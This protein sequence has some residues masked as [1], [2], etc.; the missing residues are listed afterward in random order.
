MCQSPSEDSLDS[1]ILPFMH[2]YSARAM[3][4]FSS[5]GLHPGQIPV[6]FAIK[7]KEGPTL[8]ELADCLHIKPP[9]VT[10]TVQRLEKAGILEKK[11]DEKDQ[12]IYHLYLTDKGEELLLRAQKIKEENNRLATSG[13]TE[14]DLAHLKWC[15]QTMQQNL[16]R[17]EGGVLPPL[18][19]DKGGML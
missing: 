15:L 19:P 13:L 7:G 14:E 1:W 8:R 6:L 5:L 11:D 3:R 2:L 4:D 18:C 9:T 17:E 12:R 10:V 16:L